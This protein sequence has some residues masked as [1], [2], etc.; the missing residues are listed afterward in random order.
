[1]P[2]MGGPVLRH[3]PRRHGHDALLLRD[4]S[5]L[6]TALGHRR[7]L[8]RVAERLVRNVERVSLDAVSEPASRR[9]V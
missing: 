4:L 8:S 3:F 5:V 6:V 9:T 1:L 7:R 2:A